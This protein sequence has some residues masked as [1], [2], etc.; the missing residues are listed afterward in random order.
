MESYRS[1]DGG[2]TFG[3]ASYWWNPNVPQYAHADVHSFVFHPEYGQG[4]NAKELLGYAISGPSFLDSTGW[5]ETIEN[6]AHDL[7]T[8]SDYAASVTGSTGAGFAELA[9]GGIADGWYLIYAGG[10]DNALIGGAFTLTVTAVP[11]PGTVTLLLAGVG[12]LGAARHR[13]GRAR[14]R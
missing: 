14:A 1:D 13:Q 5:G 10:T 9:L 3:K 4:G 8:S 2:A 6:G 12:V 7:R 11:E